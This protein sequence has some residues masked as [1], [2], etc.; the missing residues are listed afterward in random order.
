MSGTI[1]ISMM[2]ETAFAQVSAMAGDMERHMAVLKS[3]VDQL[4]ANWQGS[5]KVNFADI[6][7]QWHIAEG[8]LVAIEHGLL[9][10]IALALRTVWQNSVDTED[11]NAAAFRPHSTPPAPH[12]TW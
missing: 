7:E 12:R 8:N 2:L 9:G 10:D 6:H 11:G 1:Q 5:A 3:E 4:E